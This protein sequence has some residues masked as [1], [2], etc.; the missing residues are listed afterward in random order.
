MELQAQAREPRG[1]NARETEPGLWELLLVAQV[2]AVQGALLEEEQRAAAL[3][4]QPPQLDPRCRLSKVSLFPN[5]QLRP[6]LRDQQQQLICLL[7]LCPSRH[8]Q[9]RQQL[10]F[11]RLERLRRERERE[12]PIREKAREKEKLRKG[13]ANQPKVRPKDAAK[14]KLTTRGIRLETGTDHHG[15]SRKHRGGTD[16]DTSGDHGCRL[17]SK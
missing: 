11:P 14:P 16:G 13:K 7:P 9:L 5:L 6:A 17:G 1:E 10:H 15:M 12:Q 3:T 4:A 2:Q 8:R